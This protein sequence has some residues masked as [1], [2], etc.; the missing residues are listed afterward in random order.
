MPYIVH[1]SDHAHAD[2]AHGY[3]YR[4][5]DTIWAQNCQILFSS[6]SMY[7]KVNIGIFNVFFKFESHRVT[8]KM[9]HN[10]HCSY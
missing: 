5:L 8:S 6:F 2:H 7:K 10:Y 1:P 3:I 9:N 4:E